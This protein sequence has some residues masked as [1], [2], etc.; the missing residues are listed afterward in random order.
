MIDTEKKWQVI[1][2]NIIRTFENVGRAKAA[3]ELTRQG[4]PDLARKIMAKE[5]DVCK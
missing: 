4:R 3:A 1:W 5:C 2:N